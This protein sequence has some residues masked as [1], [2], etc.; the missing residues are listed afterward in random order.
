MIQPSEAV[1][2]LS[3]CRDDIKLAV[4]TG[5]FYKKNNKSYIITAWHNVSGRHSETLESLSTNLSVPNKIIAT[6][7]QQISQ[8]EFNGCVKMSISLP[9]EKDGKPTY[10]I[11]PQGWPKVDVVAIPIDLTKEYLSEG[12]LIDGKKINIST[13]LKNQTSLGLSTDIV[14]IQDLELRYKDIEDYSDYLYA[15]EDIFIV[16][17]PKG[18][19]DYTGQPIWK[20]AT[21]ASNPH[22]GWDGQ[23]Q[24]LVDCASKQGMSGAPAFFYNLKGA[25]MLGNTQLRTS[26]PITVFHGIYVGRIGGT[27]EFEAQIGRVWKKKVIEEIIDNDQF[28]YSPDELI[29]FKQD[30]IKAIG[31]N[32]PKDRKKYAQDMLKENSMLSKVFL[33]TT[34]QKLNGRANYQEVEKYILEFANSL[35][36]E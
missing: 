25:I 27:S 13:I 16:G 10:L 21:V 19:T 29:L 1:V 7:S 17:Y 6:F 3:I 4:G 26:S 36:N 9:L 12:S 31:E 11:H 30:I 22:L 32:W 24:F 23:E 18:I 33:N 5:V 20:R 34:M 8:G 2:H 35:A 14:H 28:D 15:S